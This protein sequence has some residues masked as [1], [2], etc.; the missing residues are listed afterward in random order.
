MKKYLLKIYKTDGKI[1]TVRTKK[2]KRFL[3]FIRTVNWQNSIKK[4]YIKVSYGKRM[5]ANNCLCEFYNDGSYETKQE[6]V[7]AF[8]Y[9]DDK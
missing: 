6:L 2:E 3:K 9:F 5:C 8:N 1:E 4:A 7:E